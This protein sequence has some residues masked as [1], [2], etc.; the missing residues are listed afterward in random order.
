MPK[1]IENENQYN[2]ALARVYELMQ[3]T[4]PKNLE[5][6]NELTQ[7]SILVKEYELQYYPISAPKFDAKHFCGELK[8]NEDAVEIQQT[9][10]DEWE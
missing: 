5:E 10:R 8:T 3:I 2:G 6:E 9:L 7:L 1:S 4:S